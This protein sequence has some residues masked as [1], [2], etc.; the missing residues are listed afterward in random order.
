MSQQLFS[1]IVMLERGEGEW[2]PRSNPDNV[3]GFL[4][5]CPDSDN[6]QCTDSVRHQGMKT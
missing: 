4:E 2:D 1:V 3:F 6:W 5:R